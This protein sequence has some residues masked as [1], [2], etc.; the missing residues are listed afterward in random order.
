MTVKFIIAVHRW[1]LLGLQLCDT[2]VVGPI[3][4]KDREHLVVG[5]EIDRW[6]A[7]TIYQMPSANIPR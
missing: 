2:G 1:G 6:V 3:V 4:A 5:V 7:G